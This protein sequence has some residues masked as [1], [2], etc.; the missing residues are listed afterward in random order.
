MRQGY[1]AHKRTP[2][3]RNLQY[4]YAYDPMVVLG[5]GAFPYERG[6]P[7]CCHWLSGEEGRGRKRVLKT[8]ICEMCTHSSLPH[9]MNF[10]EL[11]TCRMQ[12][13]LFAESSKIK[14]H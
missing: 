4:D 6:T 12:D 5:G 2:H 11:V 10:D 14:V 13:V 3:P 9:S 8:S 1:L 7:C